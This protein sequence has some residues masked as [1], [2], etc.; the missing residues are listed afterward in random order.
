MESSVQLIDVR[1]ELSLP[2]QLLDDACI[3]DTV[4]VVY[5]DAKCG[6]VLQKVKVLEDVL[7]VGALVL[8][9]RISGLLIQVLLIVY[10]LHERNVEVIQELTS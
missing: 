8:T 5:E 9:V 1:D 6:L 2:V 4:L 7:G 3:G 10:E